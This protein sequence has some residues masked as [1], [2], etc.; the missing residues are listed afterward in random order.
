MPFEHT[1]DTPLKTIHKNNISTLSKKQK[2]LP[3][4]IAHRK[5]GPF[6]IRHSFLPSFYLMHSPGL[7]GAKTLSKAL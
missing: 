5:E 1:E 4:N 2:H 6:R 7:S 3:R